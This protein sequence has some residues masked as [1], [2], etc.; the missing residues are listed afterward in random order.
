M[1]HPKKPKIPSHI[2]LMNPLL[3][4][5]FQLG[6]SGTADEILAAVIAVTGMDETTT[7]ARLRPEAGDPTKPAYRLAW[8]RAYLKKAGYLTNNGNGVWSLT[9]KAWHEKTVKPSLIK[10]LLRAPNASADK[11]P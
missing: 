5:L 2:G 7:T 3:K 4:A 9:E 11:E 8:A 1:V 10:K 6:G